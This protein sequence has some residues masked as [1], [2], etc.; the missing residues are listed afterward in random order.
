MNSANMHKLYESKNTI[1]YKTRF[2]GFDSDVAVKVLK[3]EYPTYDQLKRFNNEFEFTFK[4]RINGVRKSLKKEKIDNR[5]ALLLEFFDGETLKTNFSKRKFDIKSFLQ[6]AI[7][8]AGTLGELHLK[9]IIHRDINS[10]NI[11]INNNE[12]IAIIDFGIS[13]LHELKVENTD[14]PEQLEGTLLYISPEQTGRM[15]RAVDYRTD[16]YSLG[17]VFYELLTGKMPFVYS[18]SMKLVHAHIAEIPKTPHIVDSRIPPALSDL[19]LKLISKNAD[20][21]YQSAFGLKHDLEAILNNLH[22]LNKLEKLSIGQNDFSGLIT[23]PD[24]LFGRKN[25][26]EQLTGAFERISHGSSELMLITGKPGVGKTALIQEYSRL[27]ERNRGIFVDGKFDPLQMNVPY[28][29]L[30]KAFS[31]FVNFVLTQKDEE[32]EYWRSLIQ[33]TVG[34]V[35]K[36]L[37]NV[38]PG[39]KLII[40]EQADIPEL[41]GKEAQNRFNYAWTSIIKAICSP[42]HPLVLFIDDVHWADSASL[43]LLKTILLDFEINYF[44]S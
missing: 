32:L 43:E 39:L 6:I 5:N 15:N 1:I 23:M 41:E 14:K 18:D 9:N 4:T 29:A 12:E 36:V 25:E 34:N 2:K 44:L 35:G 28:F 42:K 26:L 24:E 11:L 20:D 38:L 27:I 40:G 30:I 10:N 3:A 7:K 33:K 37:T 13:S 31:N 16:L 8:I 22:D 17:I 19:I 21:R